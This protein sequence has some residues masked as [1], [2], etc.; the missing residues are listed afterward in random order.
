MIVSAKLVEEMICY[1]NMKAL[2][3]NYSNNGSKCF[4]TLH[5][6]RQ[7]FFFLSLIL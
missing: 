6:D 5:L 7:D 3:N 2:S 1:K 4:L